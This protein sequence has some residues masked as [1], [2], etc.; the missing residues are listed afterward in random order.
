MAKI[1]ICDDESIIRKGQRK[2]IADNF[3]NCEIYEAKNGEELI[4]LVIKYHP[5]LVITDIKMPKIDG[6]EA[7]KKLRELGITTNFIIISGY[8]LFAYA[9]KAIEY[10]VDAYLLKPFD[11]NE[12]LAK[13]RQLIPDTKEKFSYMDMVTYINEHFNDPTLN[14][15]KMETVFARGRTS[16]ND[17]FK[18]H[19]DM[20]PIE[21]INYLKVERAKTFLLHSQLKIVEI[22]EELH[23]ANQHYFSKV[24]KDYTGQ[25]PS[26]Y[27]EAKEK[28]Q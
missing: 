26:Q 21:Y 15:A 5:D 28:K 8:E 18:Q 13:I 22:A 25:T 12:Y 9:K 27:K 19:L 3:K 6:L 2:L 23:F 1:I 10:G 7:I 4:E 17:Y 20:T 11:N 16:I 24:F 14:L